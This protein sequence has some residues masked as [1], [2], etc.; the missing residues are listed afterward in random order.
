MTILIKE[1]RNKF[2]DY[3]EEVDKFHSELL[4]QLAIGAHK[5]IIKKLEIEIIAA[6][7]IAK[8]L[9]EIKDENE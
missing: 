1:E 9:R 7:I 6:K 2:A 4:A 8:M 3:L 5:D